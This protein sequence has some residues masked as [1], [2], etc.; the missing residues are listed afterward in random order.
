MNA[1]T[2]RSSAT[3]G[4]VSRADGKPVV[5]DTSAIVAVLR[6]EPSA[7]RLVRAIEAA[8]IRRLSEASLVES[9]I[10]MQARYG[11]HGEREIDLFVQRLRIDVVAV[12]AEHAEL[13]RSAYRRFGKGRHAA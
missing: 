8:P 12:S 9:G 11:D 7:P 10:V 5:L 6:N 2:R 1:P 13:A 3:T 4:G